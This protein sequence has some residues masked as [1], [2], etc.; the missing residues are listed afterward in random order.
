MSDRVTDI[1]RNGILILVP[2]TLIF[3]KPTFNGGS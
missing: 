1:K 3:S 2:I